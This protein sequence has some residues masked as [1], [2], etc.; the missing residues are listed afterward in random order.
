[1][2][3]GSGLSRYNYVTADGVVTLLKKVWADDAC[4]V[5]SSPALPVGATTARSSNRMKATEL[6]RRVQAKTDRSPTCDRCR[7][8]SRRR[9]ANAWCSR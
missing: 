2:H 3:D 4:A 1:M 8:F 5:R 9:Q 6:D 7:G